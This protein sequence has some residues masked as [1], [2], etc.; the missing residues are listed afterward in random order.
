MEDTGEIIGKYFG[1]VIAKIN[2]SG[3]QAMIIN[4]VDTSQLPDN[5][6]QWLRDVYAS[7]GCTVI[8]KAPPGYDPELPK[9]GAPKKNES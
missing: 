4:Y 8:Q 9:R 2:N 6:L 5:A 3:T 7:P 1:T